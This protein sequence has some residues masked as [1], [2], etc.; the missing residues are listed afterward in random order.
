MGYVETS[1]VQQNFLVGSPISFHG[2]WA[3]SFFVVYLRK[4]RSP[5]IEGDEASSQLRRPRRGLRGRFC[6]LSRDE[7]KWKATSMVRNLNSFE[8]GKDGNRYNPLARAV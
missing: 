6:P 4:K 1:K 2:E 7:N 5:Y 8:A 3:A